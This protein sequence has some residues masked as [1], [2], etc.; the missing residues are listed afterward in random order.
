MRDIWYGKLIEKNHRPSYPFLTFLLFV[1]FNGRRQSLSLQSQTVIFGL[2][3]VGH[4]HG[5]FSHHSGTGTNLKGGPPIQRGN[6]LGQDPRHTVRHVFAVVK[7]DPPQ[8]FGNVWLL[9][10]RWTFECLDFSFAAKDSLPDAF[11]N[12][13]IVSVR[14]L[15]RR[16]DFGAEKGSAKIGF[17][18]G[19][20][21]Q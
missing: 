16:R 19:S 9:G 3:F 13:Q 21:I 4:E 18:S 11:H 10:F 2:F 14:I 20:S 15:I 12:Q 5:N 17:G 1:R 8:W 6:D 7:D